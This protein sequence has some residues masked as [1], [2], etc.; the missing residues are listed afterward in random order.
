[1]S[2]HRPTAPLVGLFVSIFLFVSLSRI[3]D[4]QKGFPLQS[5]TQNSET[6]FLKI[7]D[8]KYF[9]FHSKILL[10]KKKLK[11]MEKE[12]KRKPISIDTIKEMTKKFKG[13]VREVE[14]PSGGTKEDTK[15]VWISR[16]EMEGFLGKN[17]NATGMRIYFG[18][19]GVFKDYSCRSGYENQTNLIFVPTIVQPG[20]P[21]VIFYNNNFDLDK[22]KILSENEILV[23]GNE[24][25][26]GED[27]FEM[28]PPSTS[29]CVEII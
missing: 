25:G 11:I 15:S 5:L 6:T 14:K 24:K 2:I 29:G 16:E 10:L 3:E 22:N 27:D 19:T 8:Y 4:K 13:L 9:K 12:F 21:N 26:S 23:S 17:L 20:K 28:C 1:M 18:C 7:P